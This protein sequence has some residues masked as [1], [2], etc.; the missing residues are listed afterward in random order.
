MQRSLATLILRIH[1]RS[2]F[3]VLFDDFNVPLTGNRPNIHIP[4]TAPKAQL[5]LLLVG[6]VS[7]PVGSRHLVWFD[8]NFLD[9]FL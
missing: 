6:G 5:Q 3:Q 4:P 1:I 7:L 2:S 8:I 9:Q